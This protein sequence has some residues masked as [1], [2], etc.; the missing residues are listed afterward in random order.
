MKDSTW[1]HCEDMSR[2]RLALLMMLLATVGRVAATGTLNMKFAGFEIVGSTKISRDE[3]IASQKMRPGKVVNDL[4]PKAKDSCLDI[5]KFMKRF[6]NP[7][8]HSCELVVM[9]GPEAYLVIN[10][11]DTSDKPPI[12]EERSFSDKVKLAP[13]LIDLYGEYLSLKRDDINRGMSVHDLVDEAGVLS[14]DDQNISR[15]IKSYARYL[16]PTD[17]LACAQQCASLDDR[18]AAYMEL[19]LI[20][21]DDLVQ[22][23]VIDGMSDPD[24]IV[25]NNATRYIALRPNFFVN[26]KQRGRMIGN[27]INQLSY[28]THGDRNKAIIS[29]KKIFEAYPE[30]GSCYWPQ[31]EPKVSEL[32]RES[33]LSNVGGEARKLLTFAKANFRKA[34]GGCAAAAS[35]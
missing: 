7:V 3:M 19:N 33:I 6:K 21:S 26:G 8:V 16:R 10:L 27:L 29:I 30:V 11:V 32:A 15:L 17:L 31:A 28:P 24:P 2:I 18:R 13:Q 4:L 34:A 20:P 35:K 1:E 12:V 25:R 9:P 22:R 14:T 23:V 5:K